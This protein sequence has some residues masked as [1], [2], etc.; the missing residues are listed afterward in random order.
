MPDVRW[1]QLLPRGERGALQGAMLVPGDY[2][3]E[4]HFKPA[5]GQ[6]HRTFLSLPAMSRDYCAARL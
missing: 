3:A 1:G 5:C 2:R 4:S 6:A